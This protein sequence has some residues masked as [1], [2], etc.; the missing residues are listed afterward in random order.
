MGE[1]TEKETV[2]GTVYLIGAG[3]GDE[4]LL[5]VKGRRL[6]EEADVIIYDHL[7]NPA[8]LN[9]A[10]KGC[11]KIYAGKQNRHHTMPQK[12]I[13]EL[14]VKKARQYKKVV[15]LKGG[16]VYVFGRGGEEG[17]HL[18]KQGIPFEVVPGVSSAIAGLAYAGIPVTHRGSARGFRIITA[19]SQDGQPADIDYGAL[20]KTQ[21]TCVFLM[22]FSKLDE[23]AHNMIE[24]GAS[25]FCPA[26]VIS[27]ATLPGQQTC[28]GTLGTIGRQVKESFL[29]PPALIVVGEVVNLRPYLNFFE[30]KPLFG[31]HYLV[32]KVGEEPSFLTKALK[33]KGAQVTEIQTGEI[34]MFPDGVKPEILSLARWIVLNIR[35]G[36]DA[37]F[38]SLKAQ[39]MDTRILSDKK[40]AVIGEKTAEALEA[41]GI[42]ADLIPPKFDSQSL[43]KALVQV[44]RPEEAVAY[45]I[46]AGAK[47]QEILRLKEHCTVWEMCLYENQECKISMGQNSNSWAWEHSQNPVSGYDGAFF[48]CASSVNRFFGSLN[49]AERKSFQTGRTEAIS[50]G[51]RTTQALKEWGVLIIRQSDIST[52]DGMMDIAFFKRGCFP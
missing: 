33:E 15:R 32:T 50:I 3:P 22:G 26:A 4:G 25:P 38:S 19:H 45:G 41:Y 37:F 39:R 17:I 40:F 49:E 16:D 11:E 13:N 48:T 12:E 34:R 9:Y 51:K 52:Y 27:N 5:T 47:N 35:H 20:A 1:K 28:V 18:N 23:L 36:V 24:A 8:L 10:K 6:I 2:S 30:E 7:A 21:D 46:P 14:L 42:Y 31:K 44:V 43:W 29:T